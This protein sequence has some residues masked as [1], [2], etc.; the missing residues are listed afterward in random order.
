MSLI[1][2]L[3]EEHGYIMRNG[4]KT[5]EPELYDKLVASFDKIYDEED[6]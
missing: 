4:V 1:V 5:Y 3:C 6:E 2:I